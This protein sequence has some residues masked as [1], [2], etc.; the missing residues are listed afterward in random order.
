MAPQL[1]AV[2]GALLGVLER[3]RP[4]EM[5][6]A[7]S[8]LHELGES[9]NDPKTPQMTP[10]GPKNG[11]KRPQMAQ[12]RQ[13]WRRGGVTVSTT[14]GRCGVIPCLSTRGRCLTAHN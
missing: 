4:H 6:L 5:E 1:G 7:L 13:Q 11:P 12:N 3:G 8:A 10:K 9:P 2:L 14:R